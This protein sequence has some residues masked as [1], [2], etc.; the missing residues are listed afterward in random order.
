MLRRLPFIVPPILVTLSL[1]VIAIFFG[2]VAPA[3]DLYFVCN[4]SSDIGTSLPVL[5]RS[6]GQ[7]I[8]PLA[9]LD[10]AYYRLF[11]GPDNRVYLHQNHWLYEIDAEIRPLHRLDGKITDWVT[12]AGNGIIYSDDTNIVFVSTVNGRQVLLT[13][14][15]S[16]QYRPS[17]SPTGK[18]LAYVDGANPLFSDIVLM[19]LATGEQRTIAHGTRP[20]W[21]PD[22]SRLL[23]V[24]SEHVYHIYNMVSERD[25][26]LPLEQLQHFI[27]FGV[28]W[29]ADGTHLLYTDLAC[30]T[31]VLKTIDIQTFETDVLTDVGD[32]SR[33]PKLSPIGTH[34]AYT[35]LTDGKLRLAVLELD[36]RTAENTGIALRWQSGP[37]VWS[38]DGRYI[39]TIMPRGNRSQIVIYDVH[40]HRVRYGMVTEQSFGKLIWQ[41]QVPPRTQSVLSAG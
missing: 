38:P 39:A 11:A 35:A 24:D 31:F 23:Y 13:S 20:V 8:L 32:D 34:V 18:M 4:Q 41:S 27:G 37:I 10:D 7:R 40:T 28:Q 16:K 9:T 26:T 6:D 21:S 22:G 36:T 12:W 29:M 30:G 14:T 15:T 17:L 1:I 3:S 5:M 25:T 33:M 19:V 2:R